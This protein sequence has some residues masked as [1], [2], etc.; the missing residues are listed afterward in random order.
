MKLFT[1]AA[2]A[3]TPDER[4]AV[5]DYLEPLTGRRLGDLG[6]V[7]SV[8]VRGGRLRVRIS[9]ITSDQDYL[10][11]LAEGLRAGLSHGAEVSAAVVDEDRRGAISQMLRRDHVRPGALGTSTRVYAIASGKGGVGK[12]TVTANLAA[13][14]ARSGQRVGVLDA[15]VWGYSQPTLFGVRARPVAVQGIMLPVLVHGVRLMSVGFFVGDGEPVVW[16]GPM[17]HKALEQFLEDVYWGELDVLLVDLPPGTGDVALSVLELLPDAAM[18]VVTTP[19]LAAETVAA[20]VARMA[21]DS[22]MPIAG[23]IENMSGGAFGA[24]GGT[25]LAQDVSAPLLGT[26]PLHAAVCEAGD[27]GVPLVLAAPE[28]PAA[29]VLAGIADALPV[30]HRSLVGRSLPLFVTA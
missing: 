15:D 12:S 22:R 2:T 9:G 29:Q 1:G 8:E 6:L 26:V 16:R 24:G 23:V 11:Q 7:D 18:V 19:Q 28:H 17:L 5:D 21:R 20:R 25:A 13:A 4:A 30:M 27:S 10:D 14:L 3:A